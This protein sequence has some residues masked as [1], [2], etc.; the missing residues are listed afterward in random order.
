MIHFRK[1]LISE[2][3]LLN[4]FKKKILSVW[5]VKAPDNSRT[6]VVRNWKDNGDDKQLIEVDIQ[7]KGI[8][9]EI[10]T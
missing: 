5:S 8:F 1:E 7:F 4:F 2:E 6:A 3:I 10:F 9:L